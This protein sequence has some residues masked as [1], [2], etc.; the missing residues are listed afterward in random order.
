[1]GDNRRV[2]LLPA[3]GVQSAGNIHRQ[4]RRRVAVHALDGLAVVAR[5]RPVQARSQQR[6]H[7]QG[8]GRRQFARIALNVAA[9]G[10]IVVRGTARIALQAIAAGHRQQP[11][12]APGLHQQ[13]RQN[14]A[15]TAIV[16][17]PAEN[18]NLVGIGPAAV[19][20]LGQRRAS[21]AHQLVAGYAVKRYRPAVEFPHLFGGIKRNVGVFRHTIGTRA[22]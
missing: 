12:A 22:Q 17:G 8:G 14:V 21:A 20:L 3:V 19:N 1:M 10:T 13:T 16:A 5:H 6:V 2:E 15:V 11:H 9:G 4:R 18:A 7:Q